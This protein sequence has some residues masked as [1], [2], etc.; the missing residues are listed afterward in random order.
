MGKLDISELKPGMIVYREVEVCDW[1]LELHPPERG[2]AVI[3]VNGKLHVVSIFGEESNK[4]TSN[5]AIVDTWAAAGIALYPTLI[6]A[7]EA[8]IENQ[9]MYVRDQQKILDAARAIAAKM[10]DG[11]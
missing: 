10:R 11:Q 5:S 9:E 1:V 4:T 3:E 7:F 6:E 2:C 8:G